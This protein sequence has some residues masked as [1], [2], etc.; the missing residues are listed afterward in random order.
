MENT[1]V[2]TKVLKEQSYIVLEVLCS[3]VFVVLEE[4]GSRLCL[5][6]SGEQSSELQN[7]CVLLEK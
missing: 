1:R 7:A 3:R 6:L 5:L 4:E 2:R